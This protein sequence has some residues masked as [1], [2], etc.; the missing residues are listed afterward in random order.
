MTRQKK[1]P[2]LKA[3]LPDLSAAE[4]SESAKRWKEQ[5]YC[6]DASQQAIH[7]H[8]VMC[9]VAELKKRHS[10]SSIDLALK[11][12]IRD[13]ATRVRMK[14]LS[15]IPK[16]T[17]KESNKIF[18][19]ARASA[20]TRGSTGNYLNRSHLEILGRCRDTSKR[21]SLLEECASKGWTADELKKAVVAS[22]DRN[23]VRPL[24][25][26][27]RIRASASKLLGMLTTIEKDAFVDAAY[28]IRSRDWDV[29]KEQLA[30]AA[31]ELKSLRK[32]LEARQSI[33]RDAA[34]KMSSQSRPK[35]QYRWQRSGLDDHD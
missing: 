33:L 27:K 22:S 11:E 21:L 6:E 29:A 14:R 25:L 9:E 5:I 20:S 8:A 2:N 1:A 35:K 3:T 18:K 10:S 28:A 31:E 32:E 15:E 7:L 13:G 17:L 23:V 24:E 4:A 26:T 19:A 34:R 16:R 30:A 12:I